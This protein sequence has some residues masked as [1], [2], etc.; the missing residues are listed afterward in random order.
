MQLNLLC[1]CSLLEKI[2]AYIFTHTTGLGFRYHPVT[3]H[4]LERRMIEIETQYGKIHI[5]IGQ[6][7][8][9][10]V[11]FA[12]EYEDCA[13]LARALKIPLKEVFAEANRI[14]MNQRSN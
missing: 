14:Y 4:T 10:E 13:K 6:Y 8:G 11:S 1:T 2:E 3:R 5:K 7:E 12:P 9:R